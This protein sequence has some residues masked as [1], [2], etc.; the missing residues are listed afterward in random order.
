MLQFFLK[1]ETKMFIGG[2]ME[3]EQIASPSLPH[4]GI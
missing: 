4:L 3:T 1:G 2:D